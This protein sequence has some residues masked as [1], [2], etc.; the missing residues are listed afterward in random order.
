MMLEKLLIG[1]TPDD[2]KNQINT[3]YNNPNK[4]NK[5]VKGFYE[6]AA[7]NQK[8]GNAARDQIILNEELEIS[9]SII[10][11]FQEN[12]VMIIQLN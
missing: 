10:K 9:D 8:F 5:A 2:I 1:V 3:A 12:S 7:I 6:Q 11:L 4:F